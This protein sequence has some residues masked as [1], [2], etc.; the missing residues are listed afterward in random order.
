MR[1]RLVYKLIKPP[2]AVLPCG[3]ILTKVV[4]LPRLSFAYNVV[5]EALVQ[6]EVGSFCPFL[7]P[8]SVLAIDLV[9]TIKG[10]LRNRF[11]V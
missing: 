1:V 11:F 2:L 9:A 4:P 10:S 3:G 7:S 6:Q 8:F 5:T